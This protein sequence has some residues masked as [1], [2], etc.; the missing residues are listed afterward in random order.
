MKDITKY[1]MFES[2]LY[3]MYRARLHIEAVHE[4]KK[5][6]RDKI[7]EIRQRILKSIRSVTLL[8]D[9]LT[10]IKEAIKDMEIVK[11]HFRL[12]EYLLYKE[13]KQFLFDHDVH[14]RTY[15]EARGIK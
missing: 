7:V 1:D 11:G 3:D 6:H 9:T 10:T 12:D 5:S 13:Y 4:L 2:Y 14:K 15:E 8:S